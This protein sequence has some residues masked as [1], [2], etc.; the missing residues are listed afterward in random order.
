MTGEVSYMEYYSDN[1]Y[2]NMDEYSRNWYFYDEDIKVSSKDIKSIKPLNESYSVQLWEEYISNYN[3]HFQL[4]DSN[5]K[6]EQLKKKSYNWLDD[7][8]NGT[9]ENFRNYLS[10]NLPYDQ[11]DTI[12][13][14]WAKESAVETSWNV[15]IKNWANFLFED[16]GVIL[17]N[18]NNENILVFCSGG[19]L[20]SGKRV[21][22]I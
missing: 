13:L 6:L 21:L 10:I 15:F 9:Y 8:N 20:L 22:K 5:D 2:I 1:R 19:V 3:R 7:W 14:F 18:T 4:L 17:I 16:E 12:I 11:C